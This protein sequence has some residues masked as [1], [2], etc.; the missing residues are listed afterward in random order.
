[1]DAAL[2]DGASWSCEPLKDGRLV[3]GLVASHG[4][5]ARNQKRSSGGMQAT[6]FT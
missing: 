1:M 3:V 6:S 2:H 4:E 5:G